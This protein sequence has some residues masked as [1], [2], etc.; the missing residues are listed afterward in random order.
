[1]KVVPRILGSSNSGI[2][3]D[4]L[5]STKGGAIGGELGGSADGDAGSIAEEIAPEKREA[6]SAM[7]CGRYAP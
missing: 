5:S 1:L 3:P 4:P 6:D 2:P 7:K